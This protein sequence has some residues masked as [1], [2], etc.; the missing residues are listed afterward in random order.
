MKYLLTDQ[1]TE[2]LQFRK[3]EI[4]DFEVWQELFFD[5]TTKKMLGMQAFKTSKEC[6]EKWFEWTFHRYKNNLG[7]QNILLEKSTGKIIGQAGLLVREVNGN[8]EIEIA[9]SILR[10]HRRNGFALEAIRK[11]KD[12]A[13]ENNFHE[14]LIS[15]IIPENINSKKTAEKN[16]LQYKEQIYVNHQK[17]DIHEITKEIWRKSTAI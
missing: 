16:G 15:M 1:E 13:F 2:R 8:Q 7:G 4:R 5:E 3:L 11:C 17:F 14:R 10:N 6:C 12:F 9:Y